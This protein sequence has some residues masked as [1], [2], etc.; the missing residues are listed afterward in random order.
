MG[1]VLSTV[2]WAPDKY[3]F[4]SGDLLPS[5]WY[6]LLRQSVSLDAC[7]AYQFY[8]TTLVRTR[9][10]FPMKQI[11]HV[12]IAKTYTS[13]KARNVKN[14]NHMKSTFFRGNLSPMKYK[15][16]YFIPL[17]DKHK[18][19]IFIRCVKVSNSFAWKFGRRFILLCC[20]K[21]KVNYYVYKNKRGRAK[22]KVSYYILLREKQKY[23]I[24]SRSS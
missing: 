17:Y 15:V 1:H 12:A 20:K 23:H 18:Y 13:M 19:K 5:M 24:T 11:T 22:T 21:R 6:S 4:V 8:I 16:W 2:T 7:A 9:E 10:I 14:E 3:I